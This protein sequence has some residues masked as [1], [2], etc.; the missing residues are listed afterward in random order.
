MA[1]HH[2]NEMPGTPKRREVE[3]GPEPNLQSRDAR[4]GDGPSGGRGRRGVG[5]SDDFARSFGQV[6]VND[7]IARRSNR[8]RDRR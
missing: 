5:V 6:Y 7:A 4:A 2:E 1:D 8:L 3:E